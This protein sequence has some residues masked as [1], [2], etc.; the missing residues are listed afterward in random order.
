[1]TSDRLENGSFCEI[2][3]IGTPLFL[4]FLLAAE[5]KPI[6]KFPLGKET[7]YI[8]EPLDEE[9]YIDYQSGLNDRLGKGITREK[10]ANVLIWKALGPRPEG[11]DRM[12][13]EYFKRLEIEEPPERGD[14]FIGLGT[15]MKHNLKLDPSEF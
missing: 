2:N 11:G 9:G 13:P 6:P 15:Y 10:N 1:M 4:I 7:T 5:D 14:Y 12:P 3:M 8:T